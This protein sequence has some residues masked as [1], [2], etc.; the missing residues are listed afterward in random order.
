M[1]PPALRLEA[2]SN[3]F[4]NISGQPALSFTRDQ[5]D[6]WPPVIPAS[7]HLHPCVILSCGLSG[8]MCVNNRILQKR[9]Y[10]ICEVSL[11]KSLHLHFSLYL[12][13][14]L[15]L[16]PFALEKASS[17]LERFSDEELSEFEVELR[18]R[19]SSSRQSV[20]WLQFRLPAWLQPQERDWAR[21]T[22]LSNSWIPD[23]QKLCETINICW[24]NLLSFGIT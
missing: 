23:S 11:W 6:S 3:P 7:W 21:T 15:S 8:L 13:L 1:S 4:M 18:G 16:W 22:Q 24:F 5:W 2:S 12:C 17:P 9:E 10:I 14:S 19:S 20:K